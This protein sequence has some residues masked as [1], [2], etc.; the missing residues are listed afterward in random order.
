[1][2]KF[3]PYPSIRNVDSPSHHIVKKLLA[4][5]KYDVE[6]VATEKI[7]GV[8]FVVAT[9]GTVV[10]FGRRSA[11][12]Q[13]NDIFHSFQT[14]VPEITEKTLALKQAI[15]KSSSSACSVVF[16]YGELYGGLY[17]HPEVKAVKQIAKVQKGV[18]YSPNI[19]FIAF[20]LLIDE[21][22]ASY[23]HASSLF[24]SVG[25]DY[26]KPLMVGSLKDLTS[27]AVL[28]IETMQSTIPAKFG[29]PQIA[30]NIIEGIVIRPSNIGENVII[31][32]KTKAFIEMSKSSKK[33]SPSEAGVSNMYEELAVYINLAR[34][35]NVL[36]K[37]LNPAGKSKE[38]L[39]ALIPVLRDD[40]IKD[41]LADR[42][43]LN[44]SIEEGDL[45]IRD[46]NKDASR[47][48]SEVIKEYINLAD[49]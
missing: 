23:N 33:K 40:A 38:E 36:S 49:K 20:D 16:I 2:I 31:K 44:A 14:L 42:P 29:L 8:N 13:E 22:W 3:Q 46:F 48:A 26:L 5:P 11:F 24:A 21:T 10:K 41:F 12:L 9:D 30:N 7:H 6:W 4:N 47:I 35:V 1:M 15:D 34:F 27:N 28:D 18:Y 39:F 45:D 32:R 25:L 19:H 43:E 17:R 37:E